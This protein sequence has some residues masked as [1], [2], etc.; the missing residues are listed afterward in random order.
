MAK[1][2]RRRIKTPELTQNTLHHS[3][4]TAQSAQKSAG[5]ASNKKGPAAGAMAAGPFAPLES[6]YLVCVSF[7]SANALASALDPLRAVQVT[8]SPALRCD[9]STLALTPQTLAATPIGT[10]T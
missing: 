7:W 5:P 8:G 9:A 6:G 4:E 3:T 2:M 10:L 1:K